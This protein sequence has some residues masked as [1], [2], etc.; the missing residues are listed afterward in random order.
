MLLEVPEVTGPPCLSDRV[1]KVFLSLRAKSLQ[2][3]LT[4]YDACQAPLPM[5]FLQARILKWVT[6]YPSPGGLPNPGIEPV[7]LMSP[8]LAGGFFTTSTS[9]EAH[10]NNNDYQIYNM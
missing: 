6:I 8:A 7:S 4:L 3:S 5:G 1:I 2:S 9:W 10:K